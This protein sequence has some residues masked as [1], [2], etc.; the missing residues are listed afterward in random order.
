MAQMSGE[1]RQKLKFSSFDYDY[2]GWIVHKD[3][4]NFRSELYPSVR[5]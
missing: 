3:I 2:E 5:I 4:F 1:N